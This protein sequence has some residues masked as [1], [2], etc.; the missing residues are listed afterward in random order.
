MPNTS[1]TAVLTSP[2]T[3]VDQSHRATQH[4]AFSSRHFPAQRRAEEAARLDLVT[5][6]LTAAETEDLPGPIRPNEQLAV[7]AALR[8][9]G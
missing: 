6:I 3:L 5:T 4:L 7:D 1:S 9:Y 8:V 2:I